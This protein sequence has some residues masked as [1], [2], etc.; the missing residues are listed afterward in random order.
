MIFETT[1]QGKSNKHK[2]QRQT[3]RERKGGFD[4]EESVLKEH[5]RRSLYNGSLAYAYIRRSRGLRRMGVVLEC[6]G[7]HIGRR[8]VASTNL[9]IELDP[10]ALRYDISKV[11]TSTFG[12]SY[13]FF[14]TRNFTSCIN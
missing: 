11:D 14:L 12:Q 10:V 8:D 13:I 1:C 6:L 7:S 4:I 3:A 2:W 5:F 9:R